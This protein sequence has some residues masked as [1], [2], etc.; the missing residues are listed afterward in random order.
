MSLINEALKE[1]QREA[2]GDDAPA[3]RES[4][5]LNAHLAPRSSKAPLIAGGVVFVLAVAGTWFALRKPPAE[6][7]A[8][9]VPPV[10]AAEPEA[11]EP[12]PPVA[13]KP[14]AES[15]GTEVAAVTP[16]PAEVA[17]AAVAPVAPVPPAPPAPV[18]PVAP[19][20]PVQNEQV[21]QMISLMRLSMVRKATGRA[22]IDGVIVKVGDRISEQP[23]LVLTKVGDAGIVFTD[24]AGVT[25]EKRLK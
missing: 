1:A 18:A 8:P 11:S 3:V 20:E 2:Q 17:P 12:T 13:P 21:V 4:R 23:L 7:V 5:S 6:P 19:A 24:G 25:Y 22:V 10:V 16:P 14:P 9:T 15:T